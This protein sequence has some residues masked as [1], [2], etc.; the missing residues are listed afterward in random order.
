MFDF[1][2][3]QTAIQDINQ[4]ITGYKLIYNS[5]LRH[6]WHL[7]LFKLYGGHNLTSYLWNKVAPYNFPLFF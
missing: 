5:S 1:S 4:T 6:N 2:V 7:L 3:V